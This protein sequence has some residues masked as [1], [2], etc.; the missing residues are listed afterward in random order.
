MKLTYLTKYFLMLVQHLL[1]RRNDLAHS[2]RQARRQQNGITSTAFWLRIV[3]RSQ[4]WLA[5]AE[6]RLEAHLETCLA[7]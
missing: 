6:N 1:N 2:L 5:E 4:R 7:Q 3:R